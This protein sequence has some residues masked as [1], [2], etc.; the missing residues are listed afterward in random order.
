VPQLV[1]LIG[2]A[3]WDGNRAG[4]PAELLSLRT[5]D[6]VGAR[7]AWAPVTPG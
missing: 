2:L 6:F 4:R 3:S 5:R 1:L 7:A